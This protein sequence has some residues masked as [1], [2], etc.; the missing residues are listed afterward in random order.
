MKSQT[1]GNIQIGVIKSDWENTSQTGIKVRVRSQ[2]GLE[3]N[4]QIKGRK[5]LDE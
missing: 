2:F 5:S 3:E 4:S 1:D